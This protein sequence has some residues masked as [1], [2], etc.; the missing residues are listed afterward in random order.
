MDYER[1]KNPD[2]SL[3]EWAE[4]FK[5]CEK[6]IEDALQYCNGTHELQDVADQIFNGELQLWPAKDTAL[7]SQIVVYPKRKSIHIFLAGGNIDELINMEESVFS[8]A[9]RQGCDM[10]TFSGRLGWSRSKLKNR[11][12]KADHI[13]MVKDI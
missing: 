13:M 2:G 1:Y 6:Y 11:G 7:V 5:E 8:W 12:Y 3:P 10:L 4:K 9:R